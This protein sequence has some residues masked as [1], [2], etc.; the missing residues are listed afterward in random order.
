MKRKIKL[1]FL[2]VLLIITTGCWNRVELD[3]RAIVA[4]FGA[5][6]AEEEGKIKITVQVVNVGEIKAMPPSRGVS[7]KAVTVYTGTGYT[8]F[9]AFRNLA[10]IVGKKLFLTET[11]ILVVGED[12]AR[13]GLDKVL[14]F[15]ERDPEP[16]IRNYLLIARGEAEEI[17]ETELRTDKIWASGINSMVEATMAH[18][19]APATEIIQFLKA[20]E[21]KTTAPVATAVQVIRKGNKDSGGNGKP[22]QGETTAVLP[23][24]LMVS[25]T[26]VFRQYKLAGWLD[27]KES[28]GLLWVTGK[29]KSGIIVVSS[30]ETES[31]LIA[32]EIIRSKSEIKPKITDGILTIN[33]NIKEEGNLGEIQPDTVDITKPDVFKELEERKKAA[34]EDEISAAVV[35]AQ[36][37]NADI[38]GFGEAVRRKYPKEW[39]QL[40]DTWGEIFPTLEVNIAVDAKLRRTGKITKPTQPKP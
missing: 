16:E 17:L 5:D 10:M 27:E 4:G 33:V 39:R 11:R 23:K 37:L 28:R 35:K 24:E 36:E 14:D 26:A 29:V 7:T 3:R 15:Y 31:R 34:I 32:L 13:E 22:N 19:K 25:G 12:L 8:V 40:N 18:G 20:V 21:S 9:D 1:L 38:F 6:K 2:V 30:P